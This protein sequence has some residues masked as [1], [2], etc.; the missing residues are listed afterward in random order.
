MTIGRIVPL[1]KGFIATNVSSFTG[2]ATLSRLGMTLAS[3]SS[4][5]WCHRCV[6]DGNKEADKVREEISRSTANSPDDVIRLGRF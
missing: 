5:V 6:V 3:L 1:R 4:A 2:P